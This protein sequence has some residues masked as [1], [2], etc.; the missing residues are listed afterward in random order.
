MTTGD[1]V[2]ESRRHLTARHLALTLGIVAVAA[3]ILLFMGRTPI[4]TCGYVK[5]WHGVVMSSENSQHLSDWYSPSH[6]IHGFI[7]YGL[8]W[9]IARRLP[10]GTRLV[11]ATVVE[12]AWEIVENSPWII[13]RYREAT[14][15]LDYFGDS[16]INSACD[17]LFMVLGFYLASKLPVWVTVV[18]AILLELFVGYMIRDNLTLNVIMLL[19]PLQAIRTWQGGG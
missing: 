7:F 4:C 3:L 14:I 12:S 9:L 1:V 2:E 17:I 10:I 11:I 19:W 18:V 16:V 8:L 13:N 5:L 6:V 15:S